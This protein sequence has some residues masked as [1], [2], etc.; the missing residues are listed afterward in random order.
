[1]AEQLTS[2]KPFMT[3][4]AGT[5]LW[6]AP[7]VTAR[8]P[9]DQKADIFSFGIVFFLPSFLPSFLLL[10]L[11]IKMVNLFIDFK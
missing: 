5:T 10:F 8:K 1:M 2:E 4:K 11:F 7:E 6:R 9:Y 3:A